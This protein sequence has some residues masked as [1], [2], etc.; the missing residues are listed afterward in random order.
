VKL[1]EVDARL[2]EAPL[3]GLQSQPGSRHPHRDL[4]RGKDVKG[5]AQADRL[6]ERAAFPHRPPHVL[7]RHVLQPHAKHQLRARRHLCVH[8]ANVRRDSNHVA[9]RR[10]F[11]QVVTREPPA[12]CLRPREL[13]RA[14]VQGRGR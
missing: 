11:D 3:L 1:V 8:A 5:P 7:P 6:D 12:D 14:H 9:G 4:A 2:L 10:R 13:P